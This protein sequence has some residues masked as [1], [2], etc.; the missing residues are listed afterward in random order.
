MDRAMQQLVC[1]TKRVKAGDGQAAAARMS[2]F[3]QAYMAN[4][5]PPR[6]RSL[7]RARV[8]RYTGAPSHSSHS[9]NTV[10][11]YV[12]DAP[13]AMAHGVYTRCC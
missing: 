8:R 9:R 10:Y 6:P 7:R 1:S 2:V 3:V 11:P 5:H 4:G 13:T 12:A